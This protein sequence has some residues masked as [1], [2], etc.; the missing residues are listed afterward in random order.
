MIVIDKIISPFDITSFFFDAT[1]EC[2]EPVQEDISQPGTSGKK[3][4]VLFIALVVY[5]FIHL[6]I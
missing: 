1:S 5:S 3:T 4:T 6:F 2:V